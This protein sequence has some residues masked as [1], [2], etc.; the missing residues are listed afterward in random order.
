MTNYDDFRSSL[1]GD[2]DDSGPNDGSVAVNTEDF[3]SQQ[4][5]R[6]NLGNQRFLGMTA[7]E[8]ALISV[9]IFLVVLILGITILVVTDRLVLPL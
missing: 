2:D 3:F 6:T 9:M 4:P 8:R 7:A 5:Q 1:S